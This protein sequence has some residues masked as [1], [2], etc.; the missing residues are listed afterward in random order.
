MPN[1]Q[2]YIL[3]FM[4]EAVYNRAARAIR[5]AQ[6]V[7]FET[8][9]LSSQ[10]DGAI[11]TDELT[12]AG[13]IGLINSDSA[14]TSLTQDLKVKEG[15]DDEAVKSVTIDGEVL[16][17]ESK[18]KKG[19]GGMRSK[20]STIS[21][22]GIPIKFADSVSIIL[23]SR[24]ADVRLAFS[25]SLQRDLFAFRL[26]LHSKGQ[27]S[28]KEPNSESQRKLSHYEGTSVRFFPVCFG[29]VFMKLSHHVSYSISAQD[30]S[31][32]KS[33]Y[34]QGYLNKQ[35]FAACLFLVLKIQPNS[36]FSGSHR[37]KLEIPIFCAATWGLVLLQGAGFNFFGLC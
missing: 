26:F 15:D 23:P 13:S 27:P 30:A 16:V 31:S 9:R 35:V 37:E 21:T 6:F 20:R 7:F 32:K 34:K 5:Q 14:S 28:F 4:N 1:P 12:L 17:I 22:V 29:F 25:D 18:Q 24:I 11:Q 3:C 33:L 2:K 10:P 36:F 19:G 8:K